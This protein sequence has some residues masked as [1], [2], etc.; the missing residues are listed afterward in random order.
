MQQSIAQR[1]KTSLIQREV[2]VTLPHLKFLE[3]D[4]QPQHDI[5]GSQAAAESIIVPPVVRVQLAW[6]AHRHRRPGETLD[7]AQIRLAG[8]R[9]PPVEM[10]GAGDPDYT[11]AIYS[12]DF[13][14]YGEEGRQ[15]QRNAEK[16]AEK[17][18]LRHEAAK[19]KPKAAKPEK[20][21]KPPRPSPKKDALEAERTARRETLRAK[22][23]AL[24]PKTTK[25]EPVMT[26][27]EAQAAIAKRKA[28]KAA[29][30]A[31]ASAAAK[32]R[33]AKPSERQ[34]LSE[35][36]K[37]R[38]ADPKERARMKKIGDDRRRKARRRKAENEVR[39]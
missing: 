10:G 15:R 27:A 3:A 19:P 37:R 39:A 6:D 11:A 8:G 22:K 5:P 17:Q 26:P 34:K 38:C 4:E 29:S 7:D 14:G 24:Y 13:K 16:K 35:A 20:P 1:A 36:A 2:P 32:T 23:A 18:K 21:R 12:V 30:H 28:E 25:A 33:Y 9:I 31:R